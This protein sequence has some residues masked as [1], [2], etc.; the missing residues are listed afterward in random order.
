MFQT[1]FSFLRRVTVAA[2]ALSLAALVLM[3]P[4]QSKAQS[5]L[6]SQVLVVLDKSSSMNDLSGDGVTPKWDHATQAI[7]HVTANYETSID[8]G[9]MVFP[10]PDQCAPGEVLVDVGPSTGSAINSE[11]IDPP[12]SGGNWTPMAQSLEAAGGYAPLTDPARQNF[13]LLI[14]DG[15]Q[16]CDPYDPAT[17]FI[18]IQSVQDLAAAGITIYVVGFGD[19]VDVLTLNRMAVSGGTAPPGCDETSED[20]NNPNNCYFHA[21]DFPTL[22]AALDQIALEVTQEFCD[23]VDNDCDG[24]T[25]EDIYRPCSTVCGA[26]EE[27]CVDGNWQD[28]DAQVPE[29]EECDGVD[30]DCD[31][32]TDEGCAC[33]TGD[34]RPCGSNTGECVEGVQTCTNGLWG[35]CEG[36]QGASDEECDDLDN[37]CDGVTDED[38]HRTCMTAC[39]EGEE[40]C[41]NGEWYGCTAPLPTGEICDSI[42]NDCDGEV[43]NGEGLCGTAAECIDGRCVPLNGQDGGVGDPDAGGPGANA[44]SSDSCGCRTPG[45]RSSAPKAL[46]LLI[47]L[48]GLALA[49]RRRD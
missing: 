17:R 27:T 7:D 22:S 20:P 4:S 5:C 42:D 38:L 41:V 40:V 36:Q 2:A 18:P 14:T 49:T 12:P 33:T 26:G 31:G 8:F 37:D 30:N 11:L 32:V 46:F 6:T 16:W 13:L 48:L 47:G 10:Y 43:D 34:S 1:K 9:L 24:L 29:N 44:D 25:D 39:G 45:A 19:G 23:G 15:W 3:V 35:D 28:C 21:D